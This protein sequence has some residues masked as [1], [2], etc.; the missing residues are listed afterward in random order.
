MDA[1]DRSDEKVWGIGS[2]CA[3]GNQRHE[4]CSNQ[5][6]LAHQKDKIDARHPVNHKAGTLGSAVTSAAHGITGNHTAFQSPVRQCRDD[7]HTILYFF[8]PGGIFTG[9][10][11]DG[12]SGTHKLSGLAHQIGNQ[13]EHHHQQ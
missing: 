6:A 4:N 9:T 13:P 11:A 1:P 8:V 3:A 12:F 10:L 5:H 2:R 7:G